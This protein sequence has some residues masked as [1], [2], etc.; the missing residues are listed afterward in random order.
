[1]SLITVIWSMAAATCLTLA[2]VHL[3]VWFQSR[4]RLENFF[5][6]IAAVAAAALAMQEMALMR[7]QTSAEAGEWLRWMHVS[8]AATIIAMV[9]F[10]RHYLKTGRL[11]LAWLI[12]GLRVVVLVPNFV[13]YPNATFGEIRSLNY[14]SFFGE[15]VSSPVGDSNP[16]RFLIHA[17][18]ILLLF[19]V[20]DASVSAWRK[21]T[22]E[23]SLVLGAAISAAIVLGAIFSGVMV[24]GI[25]PGSLVGLVFV[26]IVLAMAFEL[27]MDLIRVSQLSR[28]L[29]E[30]QDRMN[31]AARAASLSLWEWDAVRDAVWATD[32][33]RERMAALGPESFSFERYLELVHPDDRELV[34]RAVRRTL[35]G[36]MDFQSEFRLLGADGRVQWIAA[37][38]RL[39]TGEDGKPSRIRGVSMDVTERKRI[40]DKLQQQRDELVHFQRVSAIG[41]LSMALAH[42]LNQPLGAILRNAEAGELILRQNPADLSVLQDIFSDIQQDEQRAAA[43]IERVRSLLRREELNV[44]LIAIDELIEQ[45]A[46]LLRPE[47]QLR[48]AILHIEMVQE[49]PKVRGDRVQLQQVMLNLLLNGLEALD[50]R[51]DGQR[52]IAIDVRHSNE[53]TI[54]VAVVDSG[55]GINPDHL[56]HLFEQFFTT[57]PKGTGLGLA[58]SKTIVGAHGGQIWVENNPDGGAIFR[59]TLPAWRER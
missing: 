3:L 20:L 6:F 21:G 52:K 43:I 31:L 28:G 38:G 4:G 25:L 45:V 14:I 53:E 39:E 17:S 47:I 10:I 48:H 2:V 15:M 8:A 54:E 49:L 42:E 41:H 13:G 34:R 37:F 16:W 1:M 32:V 19:Y 7:A 18:T 55:K 22:R 26:L 35:D 9:W 5:F 56:S 24:R 30:S 33:G 11:W 12:S 51:Q 29:L 40:E 57:K 23:L 46:A 44:E 59:F 58:I 27:S 36:R 50:V